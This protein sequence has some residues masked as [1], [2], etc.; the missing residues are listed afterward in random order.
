MT[1]P[2]STDPPIR[3]ILQRRPGHRAGQRAWDFTNRRDLE[4]HRP[5]SSA[6]SP[7]ISRGREAAMALLARFGRPA[8]ARNALDALPPI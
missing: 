4:V 6:V 1:G 7:P 8:R 5:R 3:K 2:I